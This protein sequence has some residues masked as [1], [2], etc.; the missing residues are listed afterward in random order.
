MSRVHFRASRPSFLL[1]RLPCRFACLRLRCLAS[2]RPQKSFES[3]LFPIKKA[4]PSKLDDAFLAGT[5]MAAAWPPIYPS[6]YARP[7]GT[8]RTRLQTF[9]IVSQVFRP[10]FLLK[11]PPCTFTLLFLRTCLEQ[12]SRKKVSSPVPSQLKKGGV[13]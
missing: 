3:C 9:D 12:K 7:G 8:Y 5:C 11:V 13:Q 6:S 10:S 4:P 2:K 1:N